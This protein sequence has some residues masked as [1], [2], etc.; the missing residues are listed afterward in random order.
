[1]CSATEFR[2]DLNS[3]PRTEWNKCCTRV[4]AEDF[5]KHHPHYADRLAEVSEAFSS[6]FGKQLRRDYHKQLTEGDLQAKAYYHIML[7]QLSRMFTGRV[8]VQ[9]FQRRYEMA[10]EHESLK[11]H[12]QMLLRLGI[13]GMSSDESEREG[14]KIHYN[15]LLKPWR[16]PQV[17]TWLRLFDAAYHKS[18]INSVGSNT[19]GA[20]PHIR[21]VGQRLSTSRAVPGLPRNTYHPDWLMKLTSYELEDL[22]ARDKRYDFKHSAA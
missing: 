18:R 3:P 17:T 9:L 14:N 1:C 13:D 16:N 6:H 2:P 12:A 8:Y 20:F 10:L 19:R 7:S 11:P 15:V 4:F 22:Q 21:K 5:V